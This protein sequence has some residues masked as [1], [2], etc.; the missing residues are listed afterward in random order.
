MNSLEAPKTYEPGQ[1]LPGSSYRILR[2]LGQGGHASVYLGEHL[3]LQDRRAAI[4]VLHATYAGDPQ[5]EPRMRAEAVVLSQL[6]H[7]NLVKVFDASVTTDTP[8][9]PYTVM[10]YLRGQPLAAFIAAS[11]GGA[12]IPWILNAGLQ[13]SA[14]LGA[15]HKHGV[16][17]RDIKP[18]NIFVCRQGDIN[19]V[20]LIDF[21][22]AAIE[23]AARITGSLFL[24]TTRYAPVDQLNG[25]ATPQSDLY[26]Y[27]LVLYELTCGHGPFDHIARRDH[28]QMHVHYARMHLTQSPMRP[29]TYRKD[30]PDDLEAIILQCIER[31]PERR[32]KSA[33]HLE[34]ALHDVASRFY[35]EAATS[36]RDANTTEP[37]P[38]D[39]QMIRYSAKTD[40]PLEPAEPGEPDQPKTPVDA[41][42]MANRVTLRMAPPMPAENSEVNALL[43]QLLAPSE[44]PTAVRQKQTTKRMSAPAR[45]PATGTLPIP[46]PNAPASPDT[47]S[48]PAPMVSSAQTPPPAPRTDAHPAIPTQERCPPADALIQPA[49]PETISPGSSLPADP[50]APSAHVLPTRSPFLHKRRWHLLLAGGALIVLVATTIVIASTR[51][52]SF[53]AAPPPPWLVSASSTVASPPSSS[54]SPVPVSSTLALPSSPLANPP[55][56]PSEAASGAPSAPTPQATQAKPPRRPAPTPSPVKTSPAPGWNPGE[57]EQT[58]QPA[59]HPP[60]SHM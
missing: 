20:K 6:N 53:E 39:N 5:L 27:G 2:L 58:M 32:P 3:V 44:K 23:T 17:H 15:A 52:R 1:Q 54:A 7:P 29:K 59:P 41:Q 21:G 47:R 14:G 40:P 24:G 57:W 34:N 26:A 48:P 28:D 46:A 30:I 60:A 50:S 16:V 22:V 36:I 43:D 13:I 37:T 8:Q 25:K 55:A 31:E 19:V 49:R 9:R 12:A 4:K 42:P 38:L 51:G 45:Q 56:A 11:P 35:A 10:E 33:A 18:Q